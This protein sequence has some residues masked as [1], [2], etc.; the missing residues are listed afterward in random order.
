MIDSLIKITDAEIPVEV[1]ETLSFLFSDPSRIRKV[2]VFIL[3]KPK[4]FTIDGFKVCARDADIDTFSLSSALKFSLKT[5][6]NIPYGLYH[7]SMVSMRI[8]LLIG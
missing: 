6:H 3:I 4:Y 5:A 2:R 8:G 7:S 1:N